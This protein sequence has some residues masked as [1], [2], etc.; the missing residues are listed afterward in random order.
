MQLRSG[1]L[2]SEAQPSDLA[3]DRETLVRSRGQGQATACCS[4]VSRN[5]SN[6]STLKEGKLSNTS[7]NWI[8]SQIRPRGF[9]G[10]Q[11]P[12][13]AGGAPKATPRS[14]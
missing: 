3:A 6:S 11:R 10:Q 1:S 4:T 12:L 8:H 14:P 2:Y 9:R 13:A 7:E 5:V